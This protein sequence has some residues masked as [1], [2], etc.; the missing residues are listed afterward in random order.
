[1]KRPEIEN[2]L[3]LVYGKNLNLHQKV[4]AY[5]DYEKLMKYIEEL[6][7]LLLNSVSISVPIQEQQLNEEFVKT[8]NTIESKLKK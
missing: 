7:Q 4:D 6:E 3:A 1:M 2:L 8:V 5:K